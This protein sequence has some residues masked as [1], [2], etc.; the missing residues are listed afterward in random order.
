MLRLEYLTKVSLLIGL[1]DSNLSLGP[2]YLT[3]VSV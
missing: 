1:Y 3:K 2:E